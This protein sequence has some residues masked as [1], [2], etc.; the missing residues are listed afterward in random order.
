MK[1]N[2]PLI[3][4]VVLIISGFIIWKQTS[5]VDL[6][7]DTQNNVVQTDELTTIKLSSLQNGDY[8]PKTVKV[9]LG[10]KVRIEADSNTLTGSMGRLIIDGYEL[11]KDITPESNV[12][13]FIADKPG[14]FRMH[15]ANNMG[16]GTLIVK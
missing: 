9:K 11:S 4:V 15:C 7:T 1:I 12:L 3:I 8:T 5:P 13:E 6:K 10:T 2:K 14:Q 16:N